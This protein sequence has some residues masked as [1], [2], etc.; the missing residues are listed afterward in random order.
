MFLYLSKKI[1]MPNGLKVSSLSWNSEQ[2]WLACERETG[3]LKVIM[4]SLYQ[5][6]IKVIG[7]KVELVVKA[8]GVE[9][10]AHT[11]CQ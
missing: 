10:G 1:S 9:A 4:C 2:G 8:A 5:F 7:L 11:S 3:L 6:G